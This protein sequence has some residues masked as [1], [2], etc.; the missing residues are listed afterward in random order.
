MIDDDSPIYVGDTG[1]PFAP[2]FVHKDGSPVS[3]IGATITMKMEDQ[4]NASNVKICAGPWTIDDASNGKSHY[5][6]Q[7]SDVDTVGTWI[8]FITI[9]I[10]GLP[11]HADT[12]V[13]Q[14]LP[15]P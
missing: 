15:A 7:A 2:Q 9:T 10:G 13:L 3:L 1:A 11:V 5:Q 12:K 14:I 8:R 6:Y 4:Y